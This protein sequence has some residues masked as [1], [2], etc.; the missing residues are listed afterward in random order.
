[1][2]ICALDSSASHLC[3]CSR[4]S[5]YL[6]GLHHCTDRKGYTAGRYHERKDVSRNRG[7]V[8]SFVFFLVQAEPLRCILPL[9]IGSRFIDRQFNVRAIV[10]ALPHVKTTAVR[11]SWMGYD[12]SCLW[13]VSRFHE[14]IPST[15]QLFLH[16]RH[17]C[18]SSSYAPSLDSQIR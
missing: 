10:E 15:H 18:F 11:T 2:C 9:F 13:K 17:S 8:R 1:M 4:R 6:A 7:N 3:T 5:T 14:S 12:A 16:A